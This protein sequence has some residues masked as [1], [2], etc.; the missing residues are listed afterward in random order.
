MLIL[1]QYEISPFC[2][3]VRR[4]LNYKGLDY[5]VRTMKILDGRKIRRMNPTG[6]L[7]VL[8]VHGRYIGDSTD[9]VRY[10]EQIEPQPRLYPDDPDLQ[11][12]VCIFEDWADECLYFHGMLMRLVWPRNAAHWLP[13]LL[14][15]ESAWV[16]RFLGPMMVPRKLAQIARLQGVGLE[17]REKVLSRV[18][19]HL[20]AVC[21]TLDRHGFLVGSELT[22]ADIS[23][24]VQIHGI[25]GSEEGAELIAAIPEITAWM[26]RVD[27]ATGSQET[28]RVQDRSKAIAAAQGAA[29]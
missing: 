1:Y 16:Q 20:D 24:F 17:T 28:A 6:K 18:R 25:Q 29:T 15:H 26:E 11:A 14:R 3:K 9:I 12:R 21:R 22:M 7:P 27:V 4:T 8:G 19:N 5:E 13:I 23:V 2:D 10:L